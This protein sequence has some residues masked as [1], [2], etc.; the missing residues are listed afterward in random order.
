MQLEAAQVVKQLRVLRFVQP[1]PR[2]R[3]EA[4]CLRVV[5]GGKRRREFLQEDAIDG[6]MRDARERMLV[7]SAHAEPQH[8]PAAQGRSRRVLDYRPTPKSTATARGN[9]V[10]PSGVS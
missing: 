7:V 10:G 3:L 6:R 2:D 9:S 4:A 1:G 8:A 5:R